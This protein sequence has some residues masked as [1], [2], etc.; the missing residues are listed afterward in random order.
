MPSRAKH[1]FYKNLLFLKAKKTTKIQHI[2]SFKV[3]LVLACLVAVALAVEP[4]FR[5]ILIFFAYK[6]LSSQLLLWIRIGS[7][8]NPSI[9]IELKC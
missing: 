4:K 9:R 2:M 5:Y 7:G 6:N 3:A 1:L 8:L